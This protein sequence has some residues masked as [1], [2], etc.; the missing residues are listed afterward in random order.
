[1]IKYILKR[2]LY[3]IP[4]MLLVTLIVFFLMSITKGDPARIVLGESASV[5]EVE[6]MRESMGL[7]DPFFIR[8]LRYVQNLFL[9]GDLGTSYKSG[10]PVMKEITSALPSTIRLSLA[11]IIIAVL[12]GIPIGIISAT[13]QYSLFDNF[14]MILGLIGISMPVFWLGLLL[15]LLFSVKLGW[16]PPSGL[17]S[18]RHVILPAFT[19][20][21]QSIAVFARMTRS[22]MLEVIRQDYIRTVRAKGQKESRITLDHVL[23]NALVPIVTVVGIQFGNLLGGAVLCETIFSINGVGRLM[24][25]A[26]KQRDFPVVQGGVLFISLAFCL[27]NLIIDIVYAFL[28]PKIKSQYN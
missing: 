3:L 23:R 13:K 10:L 26:I 12:I 19:L 25:D 28:D 9:H 20:G 17:T 7:N 27:I 1:M 6:A 4:V 2:I 14:T 21:T 15:I 24:V 5:E 18:F 22:S 11:A 16:F 8:Y